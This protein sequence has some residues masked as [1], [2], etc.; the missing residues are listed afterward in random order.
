MNRKEIILDTDRGYH[1]SCL[2][3]GTA[4]QKAIILCLHGFAGSKK[5]P[6]LEKLHEIMSEHGIG[7]FTFD[8]PG[9]GESDSDFSALNTDN[10][11]KDV[12][13]V[14]DYISGKYGVPIC[15]FATSLGGYLAMMYHLKKPEK[16]DRIMLRS[17]ALKMGE[18]M[19][20]AMSEEKFARM[21]NGEDVDFGHGQP[22]LLG[23]S[24][25]DDL[26]QHDIYD[27]KPPYPERIRIIH[28]DN[29][30]V[31]PHGYSKKYAEK[32]GITLHLLKGAGHEY[33]N[34]GDVKWVMEEAVDF[35]VNVE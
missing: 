26:C 4:D 33:D 8:W 20:A 24:Y 32:N 16:F 22:L 13:T 3:G 27:K 12:D 11:M 23:R 35:F 25:Y 10:C 19:K 30:K 17:P 31:V 28:G 14:Y 2:D 5:S 18:V 21:M 9:H 15:C 7:T 6:T 29:D 1:I 34:P